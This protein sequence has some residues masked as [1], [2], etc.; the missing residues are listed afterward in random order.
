MCWNRTRQ[1]T[2]G[3]SWVLLLDAGGRTKRI[4]LGP[5]AT[6]SVAEARREALG[7]HADPQPE[8]AAGPAVPLF[9]DFVAGPW[10]KAHFED[11]CLHDLRHTMASHAVCRWSPGCSDIPACA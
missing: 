5:V 4:S 10:K 1:P 2:G 3:Q 7:R 8:R 9:R 6:K 11:V